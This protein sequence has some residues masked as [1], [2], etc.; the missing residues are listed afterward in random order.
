MHFGILIIFR[1]SK[2]LIPTSIQAL[3]M[4][5]KKL[6]FRMNSL[7]ECTCSC[8]YGAMLRLIRTKK[9][10]RTFISGLSTN[11]YEDMGFPF[12]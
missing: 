3:E 10:E 9:G 6:V 8:A 1:V 7:R 12:N 5:F 2:L 4:Q 11:V